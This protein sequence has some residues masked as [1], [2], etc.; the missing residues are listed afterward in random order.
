MVTERAHD[1]TMRYGLPLLLLAAALA[2]PGPARA[3]GD[4][5]HRL[6]ARIAFSQLTPAARARLRA[7]LARS[8]A[9]D[10]PSCRLLSI[11]D[12]SVW[13]DC[14]R[15]LGDRFA[16]EAPWHYQNISVCKAFDVAANCPDGA[17]VT[18][19]IPRQLR[20][21]GNAGASN[22]ARAKALA[23]VVHLVGDLHQ[24]LHV[25]EKGDR[26]G[27]DVPAAYGAKDPP[28]FNL[29]R[30]W[31]SDLAERA[32]TD[33]PALTPRSV[34]AGQRAAWAQGNVTEWARE[35]WDL[36]RTRV[37]PPARGISDGCAGPTTGRARL[38]AA[39]LAA[40]TPVIR[41]RIGQAGTR[42]ALLLN[43]ALGR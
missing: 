24:P 8:A 21:L 23:Y 3:W 27:N 5:G 32:L 14:V 39:Y 6:V 1:R 42:L 16:A 15:G 30:A 37:Y 22:A 34:T 31:D 28:R 9:V 10:T 11:E 26:G 36:S 18:A 4:Y 7:I 20:I 12:A 2:V 38:D 13:P 43:R 40:A 33:P 17:C 25:G 29:H 41:Q 35:S 19:Q